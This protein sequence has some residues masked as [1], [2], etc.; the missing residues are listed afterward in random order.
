MNRY[1]NLLSSEPLLARLSL[2]QLIAYFGAWFSNVAI[3]TLLIQLDAEP[4]VIALVAALHFFAGVLQAPLSG[5]I[6][7][8]ISPKK[9]MMILTVTE[10]VSTLSLIG[11]SDISYL[12]L[13]YI[14]VFVR[15][16]AASFQFTVE[17][18]LL[19]KIV[20]GKALQY[21]NEIHSII[22]S[23]SYTAGMALGGLLVYYVGTTVAF[24]LDATLFFVVL[25]LVST[26]KI[27]TYGE[28]NRERFLVMMGDALRYIWGNKMV[29]NLILLHAVVGLTA[30]DALVVLSV[31]KYYLEVVAISLGIGLVHAMRAI[32]LTIGPMILGTWITL[33]RLGYLFVAEGLAII[34]WGLVIEYFYLSLIV[35]VLVGFVTSTLWS[36]TFTLLQQHTEEA[37]YGRVIAYN[38]MVFLIFG[39][40]ASLLIG[41]LVKIGFSLGSVAFVFGGAFIMAAIYYAWIRTQHELKEVGGE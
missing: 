10:I 21:A 29:F 17:M 9:L 18:S 28:Q 24:L 5:V 37:Y 11:V 15:M 26:L 39:G 31:E 14:L 23:F 25:I 35:S 30:F 13:L 20:Q 33:K 4:A 16:G 38:D 36:Y 40:S 27:H 32:G 3:Y 2:I 12:L 22:W 6:I 41:F 8:R 19:P 7:D 34:L 1:W